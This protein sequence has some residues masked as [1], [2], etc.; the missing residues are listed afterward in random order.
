MKP[1]HLL[2]GAALVV[3]AGFALFGDKSP[4]GATVEPA[5]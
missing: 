3:A 4:N 1:R 2:M 5:Q